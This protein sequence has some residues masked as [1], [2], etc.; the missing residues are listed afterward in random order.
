MKFGNAAYS[1]NR[2][3]IPLQVG[4]MTLSSFFLLYF[5]FS[6]LLHQ[7]RQ[8]A[9]FPGYVPVV[10]GFV[11]QL[12]VRAVFNSLL[13]HSEIPAA[14]ISQCIQRTVTKQTVKILRISSCMTR[15]IFTFFITEKSIM[16]SFPIRF[17]H[18]DSP[19]T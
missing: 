12:A 17:L 2:T 8:L 5:V 18:F 1:V 9:V 3:H 14:F 6:Y 19:F 13:G 4:S 16:F 7:L 15:K 11:R 10:L